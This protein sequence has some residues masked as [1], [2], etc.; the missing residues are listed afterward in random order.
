MLSCF[1]RDTFLFQW[2]FLTIIPQII[3]LFSSNASSTTRSIGR[4]IILNNLGQP[5]FLSD[6]NIKLYVVITDIKEEINRSPD[7]E[8]VKGF[9]A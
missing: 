4:N 6:K 8:G 2:Y 1:K 3:K 5:W 9:V 7:E